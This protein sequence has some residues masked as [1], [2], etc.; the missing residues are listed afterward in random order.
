MAKATAPKTAKPF[1]ATVTPA[2]VVRGRARNSVRYS[3]LKGATIARKGMK[4]M[5]RTVMAFGPTHLAISKSLKA[6]KPVELLCTWDG[7]S[8]RV[9]GT[10]E[11]KAA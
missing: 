2:S 3:V 8:I 10:P 4:D 5:V 6:G 7:G 1:R 9:V 11:A